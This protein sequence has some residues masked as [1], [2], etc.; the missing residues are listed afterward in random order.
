MEMADEDLLV[1]GEVRDRPGLE[2]RLGG[3][4]GVA[5]LEAELLEGER[6]QLL[7]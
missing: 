6:G 5:V 1:E 3:L 4:E 2:H 7:A